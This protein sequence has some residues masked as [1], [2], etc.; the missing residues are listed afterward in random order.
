V[1]VPRGEGCVTNVGDPRRRIAFRAFGA[2]RFL[3]QVQGGVEDI[4]GAL[5]QSQYGVV[6]FQ[7]RKVIL[8]C[9]SIRSLAREGEIDN[10]DDAVSFDF[11]AGL[12]AAEV[13]AALALANEAIDADGLTATEWL[14]RFQAYVTETERLL[15]YDGPLPVL[16]SPDG[17]FGLISLN[18]RWSSFLNELDL[19]P[20]LLPRWGS[21]TTTSR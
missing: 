8:C 2:L 11:F 5:A 1:V 18:R 16:R 9:L 19:P 20:F 4:Q 14:D 15:D 6:A 12:T 17:A 21:P 3:N 10:D 13:A 7:A